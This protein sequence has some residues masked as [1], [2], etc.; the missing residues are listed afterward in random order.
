[1]LEWSQNTV[2]IQNK[3]LFTRIKAGTGAPFPVRLGVPPIP[4]K[5]ASAVKIHEDNL[6]GRTFLSRAISDNYLNDN[7]RHQLPLNWGPNY[8]SS[9]EPRNNVAEKQYPKMFL[10]W[11]DQSW[12]GQKN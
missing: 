6:E 5:S 2:I 11:V 10:I 8:M 1:M 7:V 9:W 12:N 4:L 3:K